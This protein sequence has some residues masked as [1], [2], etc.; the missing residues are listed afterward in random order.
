[1]CMAE[2]WRPVTSLIDVRLRSEL[3]CGYFAMADESC[4]PATVILGAMIAS[5]RATAQVTGRMQ[6]VRLLWRVLRPIEQIA[7]E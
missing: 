6:F 3:Q 7:F 4:G 2:Q 5:S 1:M